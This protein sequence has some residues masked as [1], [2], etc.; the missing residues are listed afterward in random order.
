MK[1]VTVLLSTYNGEKYLCEQIDSLLNQIGVQVQVLIRDDGSTDKTV[2][3]IKRYSEKYENI[4]YYVGRNLRPALSFLD[5]VNSADNADYYAFCDQ[6]DV[7]DDDKLLRAV[8]QLSIEDNSI[9]LLYFSNLKVVDRELNFLRFAHDKVIRTDKKNMALAEAVAT[10]CTMVFNR[11]MLELVRK[12]MPKEVSMHDAWFY[13]VAIFLGKVIYDH[14]GRI[15]YRQHENN[16]IGIDNRSGIRV[17]AIKRAFDRSEQ[18][19][20]CNARQLEMLYSGEL[21][22]QDKNNLLKIVNY[23]KSVFARLR[24]LFD[25]S[26]HAST[27]MREIKYRVRIL[28][29]TI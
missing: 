11:K 10:G 21:K 8:E 17:N 22:D 12:K 24:L 1:K 15:L 27:V 3:I 6:D 13:L 26:I 16:V 7:W 29:G 23:K 25:F 28:I 18:P 19:R 20:Y 9:P 14:E 2:E 4:N 5:L